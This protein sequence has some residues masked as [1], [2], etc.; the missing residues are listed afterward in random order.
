MSTEIAEIESAVEQN[1]R[2]FALLKEQAD[3]YANST[4]VPKEYQKNPG[5]CLTAEAD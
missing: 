3:V 1:Q 4:L 5:N 2:A